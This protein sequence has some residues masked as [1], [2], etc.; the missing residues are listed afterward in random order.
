MDDIFLA[1][2]EGCFSELSEN[3]PKLD[4]FSEVLFLGLWKENSNSLNYISPVTPQLQ[5]ASSY[6]LI[7]HHLRQTVGTG[8]CFWT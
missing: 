1:V 5:P 2:N 7:T 4:R 3:A 6:F 8:K